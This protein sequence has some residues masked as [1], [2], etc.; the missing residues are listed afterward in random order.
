MLI[1]VINYVFGYV[2]YQALQMAAL[3]IL[4]FLCFAVLMLI[5]WSNQLGGIGLAS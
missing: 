1:F 2:Q 4:L 3:Q 5:S